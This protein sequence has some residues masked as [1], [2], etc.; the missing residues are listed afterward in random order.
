MNRVEEYLLSTGRHVDQPSVF[1]ALYGLFLTSILLALLMWAAGRG[2][3]FTDEGLY[4]LWLSD[5][6]G[7]DA[8]VTQFG[9]AYHALYV[10]FDGDVATLR[11]ANVLIT[12]MLSCW[13]FLVMASRDAPRLTWRHWL[14]S[15]AWGSTGLA[16]FRTALFTPSYNSLALQSLLLSAIALNLIDAPTRR[17]QVAASVLLGLGGWLAFA[18]KPT[19]AALLAVLSLAYLAS[20]RPVPWRQLLVAAMTAALVMFVTAN[21]IDGGVTAHV[22]R[23]RLGLEMAQA[24]DAGHSGQGLMRAHSLVMPPPLMVACTL[25]F[26]VSAIGMAMTNS[27]QKA[28]VTLTFVSLG[29]GMASLALLVGWVPVNGARHPLFSLTLLSAA[30]GIFMGTLLRISYQKKLMP[31]A[32]I[33][34]QQ[35]VLA[36]VLL[37]FPVAFA[38]G[39]ASNIW[40]VAGGA[41]VFWVASALSLASRQTA[42]RAAWFGI[43]LPVSLVIMSAMLTA[44]HRDPYR[45]PGPMAQADRLVTIGPGQRAQLLVHTEFA[46]TLEGAREVARSNGYAEGDSVIDLSGQSPGLVFAL[47][48][49]SPGAAW[50]LGG[51]RGSENL[52]MVAL[53]RVP[54]EQLAAAWLIV[55][56]GGPRS[57]PMSVLD[58]LGLPSSGWAPVGTWPA[59]DLPSN[60]IRRPYQQLLKPTQPVEMLSDSCA[61]HRMQSSTP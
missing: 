39:T 40:N 6:F 14:V 16:L 31:S 52:A 59:G 11:R 38:F 35:V 2:F 36:L 29:F 17:R 54:C 56:P 25:I 9:F 8:S 55:E 32:R 50:L 12:W 1:V 49:R 30:S 5:P 53:S 13:L 61:K 45:Q 15:I 4:L 37:L 57:L 24:M 28:R 19:T 20:L 21:W 3:D 18:A 42:G 22:E 41:A 51:Y 43:G 46:T 48:G 58:R 23:M 10:L 26:A 27:S 33:S 7:F 44:A 47:G 34:P 60:R